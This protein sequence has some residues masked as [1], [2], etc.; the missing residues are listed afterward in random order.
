M[1]T[2]A[3]EE[4]DD[5]DVDMTDIWDE[6]GF[7]KVEL[8]LEAA[9]DEVDGKMTCK[10]CE[11]VSLLVFMMP[12]HLILANRRFR[13]QKFDGK[14]S[15]PMTDTTPS[16]LVKHCE[17]EHPAGWGTLRKGNRQERQEAQPA[18]NDAAAS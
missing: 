12:S 11:C 4:E 7:V 2:N 10:M 15:E 1:E 17:E 14:P 3:E 13:S 9:F 5:E 6:N 16:A 18:S 8:C